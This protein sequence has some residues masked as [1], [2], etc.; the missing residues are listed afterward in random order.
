MTNSKETASI[1]RQTIIDEDF[2]RHICDVLVSYATRNRDYTAELLE[3]PDCSFDRED[4]LYM[5]RNSNIAAQHRSV[6]NKMAFIYVLSIGI[7]VLY[8]TLGRACVHR[9]RN[10]HE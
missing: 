6:L 5:V 1:I 4:S 10:S 7:F 8:L 3:P 9:K 2:A